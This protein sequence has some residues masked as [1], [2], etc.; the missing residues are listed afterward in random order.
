MGV[1]ELEPLELEALVRRRHRAGWQE[2]E[3]IACPGGPGEQVV[4]RIAPKRPRGRLWWVQVPL[5][6]GQQRLEL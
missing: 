6:L 5:G 4:G 3:V 2:L 1:L